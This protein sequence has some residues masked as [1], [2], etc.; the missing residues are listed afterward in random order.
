MYNHCM[1]SPKGVIMDQ[2]KTGQFI[3]HKRKEKGLTQAQLAEMLGI[4]D[5]AVSKW[6]TSRSFPDAGIVPELCAI[7]GITA[8]ELYAGEEINGENIIHKTE[9]NLISALG[10]LDRNEKRFRISFILGMGMIVLSALVDDSIK[11]KWLMLAGYILILSLLKISFREEKI[12]KIISTV[13]VFALMLSIVFSAD[14]CINYLC[15]LYDLHYG[16]GI[17][18]YSSL[19]RIIFGD[20]LWSVKGYLEAFVSSLR[21]SVLLTAEN[22]LLCACRI[23]KKT[24][25]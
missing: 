20:S 12:I 16:D 11:A 24:G 1:I 18:I 5:K 13:S 2:K 25:A 6:E 23:V 4:T 17:S 21:I 14:L 15:S 8:N 3:A 9:E 10:S 22:L 7:L 19:A